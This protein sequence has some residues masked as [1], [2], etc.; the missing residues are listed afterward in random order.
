MPPRKPQDQV[1]AA[2]NA[3]HGEGRYNYDLVE[4]LGNNIKVWIICNECSHK[5]KQAPSKHQD[6]QGCPECEKVLKAQRNKDIRGH[7]T[8][9]WIA[10]AVEIHR[11]RYD[12]SLA[13]YKGNTEPIKIICQEHGVKELLRAG[14]HINGRMQGCPDCSESISKGAAA[15]ARALK[16]L[17]VDYIEE[18]TD[19]DCM[20]IGKLRFDF[21]LPKYH[22]VIEYDGKQHFRPGAW[23]QDKNKNEYELLMLRRRDAIKSQYCKAN[24]ISLM[25]ITPEVAVNE[26]VDHIDYRLELYSDRVKVDIRFVPEDAEY[27]KKVG[28]DQYLKDLKGMAELVRD[29]QKKKAH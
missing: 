16:E 27:I 2:F 13:V 12:Y 3:K 6:G 19:H 18:W 23:N 9:S 8:E 17:G 25:R 11:D 29:K 22:T 15:V 28:M 10:A 5:W 24:N 20:D 14:S 1:I 4:Y 7:T 26:M 21:Y